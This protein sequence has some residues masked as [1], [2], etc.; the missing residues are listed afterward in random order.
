MTKDWFLKL[1]D[2]QSTGILCVDL[3]RTGYEPRKLD[4]LILYLTFQKEK[5]MMTETE[6]EKLRGRKK[7]LDRIIFHISSGSAIVLIYGFTDIPREW[8]LIG[9]GIIAI[10]FLLGDIF[11]LF[12]PKINTVV[13]KIFRRMMRREETRK[14][15]ASSYYAIGCWLSILIFTRVVACI[16]ILFL[17]VC[18]TLTKI[19][20][21]ALKRYKP[22]LPFLGTLAVNFPVSFFIAFILIRYATSK[23]PFLPSLLGALGAS[24]GEAI[25][26]IDNLTIPLLSGTLLTLGLYLFP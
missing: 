13:K 5:V 12:V 26:K 1:Q 23:N 4:N 21:K 2:C 25:P 10:F 11:R 6:E 8:V 3:P 20:R 24:I 7:E 9:L 14:L 22:P 15:A 17:V 18:D 19:T 16:C